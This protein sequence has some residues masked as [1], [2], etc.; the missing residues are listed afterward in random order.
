MAPKL[1][2][3]KVATTAEPETKTKPGLSAHG[4]FLDLDSAGSNRSTRHAYRMQCICSILAEILGL[5]MFCACA[6][7]VCRLT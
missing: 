2:P 4:P 6:H 3:K 7:S 1:S 5:C